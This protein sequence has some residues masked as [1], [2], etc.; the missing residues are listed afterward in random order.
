MLT[1]SMELVHGTM[2]LRTTRPMRSVKMLGAVAVSLV[3]GL[4]AYA[5]TY[6]ALLALAST[7]G[8]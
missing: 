6:Q 4:C 2:R 1:S 7:R 8:H 3:M 5:L